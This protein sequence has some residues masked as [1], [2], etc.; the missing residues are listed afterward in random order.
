VTLTSFSAAGADSAVDLS[1]QTGSE[2]ENLGFNLYRGLSDAGPWTRIT[3]SL[4]PG[5]G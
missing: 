4:I 5:L 3:S 1:W 2:L